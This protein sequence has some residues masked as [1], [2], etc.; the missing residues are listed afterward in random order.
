MARHKQTLDD[1]IHEALT[2]MDKSATCSMMALVHVAGGG[3]KEVHSIK[4]TPGGKQWTAKELAD[5]FDHKS[6]S[7]AQDLVG[8]Q[9]FTIH[10]F[11]G[12]A[13][14][15]L[16]S[17]PFRVNGELSY[18]GTAQ[19]EGPTGTGLIQQ[20]MRHTE[21]MTQMAL[22]ALA[23]ANSMLTAHASEV[24]R[25]NVDLRRENFEAVKIV[26]EI[27]L[28]DIREKHQF[29]MELETKRRNNALIER[30]V[31]L[32]P[33]LVNSI[34]G[35]EVFSEAKEDTAL[36]EEIF[37]TLKPDQM[38]QLANVLPPRLLSLIA[39]RAERFIKEK[40]EKEK[41]DKE[42]LEGQDPIA[43]LTD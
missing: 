6:R 33:A 34:T 9:L 8:V 37:T 18:D 15:P 1:W 36:I 3:E 14:Q 43:E 25:Q 20:S 22:R 35:R 30:F 39:A 24:S 21:A 4:M 41:T 16:A 32:A 27:V 38:K 5:L 11:Y 13:T 26:K 40:T 2:D 28:G 29:Q 23:E 17:H 42:A 19:T 10:A 12:D 7:Y 31:G